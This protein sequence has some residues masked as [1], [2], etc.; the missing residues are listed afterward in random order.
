MYLSRPQLL[1]VL[2]K[3]ILACCG[4]TGD[5]N[6]VKKLARELSGLPPV[7]EKG[8]SCHTADLDMN[9]RVVKGLISSRRLS[10]FKTS[11]RRHP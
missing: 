3:C 8:M 9:N 2:W 4:G 5:I 6:R 10:I 1:L 7:K 11:V